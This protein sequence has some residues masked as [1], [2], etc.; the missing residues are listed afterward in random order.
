MTTALTH[1]LNDL[2][3]I[4]KSSSTRHGESEDEQDVTV[5]TLAG[6][7]IGATMQGELEEI[8]D[9]EE[10]KAFTTYT[11]SNFQA[12]NNSIMFGGSYTCKDPGV[13]IETS[14]DYFEPN[15][16]KEAKDG[17]KGKKKV[18][19][20]SRS[21]NHSGKSSDENSDGRV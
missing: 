15:Q 21:G 12:I 18:T 19:G 3:H 13:H 14:M 2:H 7:N 11:N 1:H 5:I 17:K 16:H 4:G 20:T 8:S 10:D 6:N 9:A